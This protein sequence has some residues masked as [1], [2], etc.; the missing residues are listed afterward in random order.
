MRACHVLVVIASCTIAF[1]Q[2]SYSAKLDFSAIRKQ[3]RAHVGRDDV[4]GLAI[5]VSKSGKVLW[6]EGFGWADRERHVRPTPTTPFYIASVTK[7]I[8]A[9][10]VLH[11]AELGKLHLD[12]PVNKYLGAAK[13][14][15]PVWNSSDATIRRVMSQTS[16]LTTFSRWCINGADLR[17]DTDGEIERYGILVWPRPGSSW[18]YF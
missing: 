16:G 12:D 3:L 8:T 15:S 7:S 11:L 4:P 13:V 6:E 18:R 14:H 10:A 5:A 2:T 1:A 17:C 9:T